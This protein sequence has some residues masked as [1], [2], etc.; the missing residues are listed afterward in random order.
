MN[1]QEVL[2]RNIT[3]QPGDNIVIVKDLDTVS[4]GMY[5]MEFRTSGG[6]MTQKIVKR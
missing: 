2:R 6:T 5:I 4:P 3:L 1:G